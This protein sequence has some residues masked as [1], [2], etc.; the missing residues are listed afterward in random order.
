MQNLN[1]T[2]PIVPTAQARPKHTRAGH[3]YKTSDQ[4]AAERTLEAMLAPYMPE[5]ALDGPLELTFTACLPIPASASK[6]AR[7]AMLGGEIGHTKKPDLDNLCKQLLDAMTRLRFWHDD[8]QLTRLVAAKRYSERPC[9]Q[10][11]V[12]AA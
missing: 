5:N 10:V 7:A 12:R 8:R 2:L 4:L 6:K 1:F 11:S 3:A 9:W